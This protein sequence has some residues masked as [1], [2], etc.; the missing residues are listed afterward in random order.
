[1]TRGR[2]ALAVAANVGAVGVALAGSAW[3][4]LRAADSSLQ[5]SLGQTLPPALEDVQ[6]PFAPDPRADGPFARR[7]VVKLRRASPRRT[8]QKP[9]VRF[10]TGR[11]RATPSPR[12]VKAKSKPV[13]HKRIARPATPVAPP[14]PPASP[15]PPPSPPPAASPAPPPPAPLAPPP[16]SPPPSPPAPPPAPPPPPVTPP[17]EP[18]PPATPPPASGRPDSGDD[19]RARVKRAKKHKKERKEKR[20]KCPPAPPA[21]PPPAPAPP[22]DPRDDEDDDDRGEDRRD[23]SHG[24]GHDKRDKQDRKKDK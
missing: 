5:T 10:E 8:A 1:M 6:V 16:P 17:A 18:S 3:L 14:P 9:L 15:P 7:P 19:Y 23:R 22:V 11:K 2:Y 24:K 21:T 4:W 12:V 20:P 13:T